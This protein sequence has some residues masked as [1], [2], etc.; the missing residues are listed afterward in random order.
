MLP[1]LAS[2]PETVDVT[3]LSDEALHDALWR[4]GELEWLLKPEQ[5]AI[6]RAVKLA[7]WGEGGYPNPSGDH[8][9]YVLELV[10]RFGKSFIC[11]VIVCELCIQKANARVHWAAETGKQVKRILLP[12]MRI[13]LAE[14]PKDLRPQ[15]K[16][17]EDKWVWANGSEIYMAGCEDEAKADR[18][19]GDGS[20]LFIP[21]EAGHI[22]PLAYVIKSIAV[23]MVS[24]TNGRILIPSTPSKSPGHPFV[25]YAIRAEAEGCYQ[26]RTIHQSD[27]TQSQIEAVW[28]ENDGESHDKSK[29]HTE[30]STE[31]MREGLAMRV[32][33]PEKAILP[34][35]SERKAIIVQAMER[36][37]YFDTY[38]SMDIGYA[39]DL[40]FH[41]FGYYDYARALLVIEDELVLARMTT[42]V[43]AA[44]ITA[45][46]KLWEAYWDRLEAEWTY[47]EPDVVREPYRSVGDVPDLVVADLARMHG[48]TV[49]KTEK[50]DKHS[51]VNGLVLLIRENRLRIHPRCKELIAH[52]EA[53]IWNA[54]HTKYDRIEGF[55]HFDG[56][57]ALVYLRRNLDENHDPAPAIPVEMRKHP[58]R[59]HI[60]PLA[61]A[62]PLQSLADLFIPNTGA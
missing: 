32:G 60:R 22:A 62:D 25:Y 57:D 8:T 12:N 29:W 42:D 56:V 50:H 35:F 52:C 5:V 49:E 6:Y 27:L 19:R 13:I 26:H 7:L 15:W 17:S 4:A 11:G 10:R 53:G 18:L 21:D 61:A 1:T 51:A 45:K 23:W 28:R 34:G 9:T 31:W 41:I 58:D 48:I 16:A 46:R 3:A 44:G 55:G 20:D 59:H 38:E 54:T 24:R 37:A 14:C 39:P 47:G 40:T 33:D 43:Y 30:G 36:P 2:S